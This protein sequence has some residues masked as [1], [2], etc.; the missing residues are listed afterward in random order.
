MFLS[1]EKDLVG[2]IDALLDEERDLLTAGAL[3]S[4]QDLLDRKEAL[5]EQLRDLED[6]SEENLSALRV[7]SE[8]NQ[9]LLEASMRAVRSVADRMKDLSRVRNSLETYTNQGER[10]A[11]PMTAGR[12]LEKRA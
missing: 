3:N 1:K 9:P 12:K 6:A 7:K 5:F 4:L 10:Y 2:E 11:V 8:R